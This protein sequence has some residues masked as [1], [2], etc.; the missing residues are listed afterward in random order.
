MQARVQLI[1][2]QT[3][4]APPA[5]INNDVAGVVEVQATAVAA[6]HQPPNLAG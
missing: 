4:E 5:T 2:D 6:P 3:D 1:V